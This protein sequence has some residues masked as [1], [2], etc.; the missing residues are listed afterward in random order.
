MLVPSF[1]PEFIPSPGWSPYTCT[2]GIQSPVLS[3]GFY[4]PHNLLSPTHTHDSSDSTPTLP[5]SESDHSSSS[6]TESDDI[7]VTM[8]DLDSPS[9]E[10]NS[11]AQMSPVPHP[12]ELH[13]F[14]PV[15]IPHNPPL[16]VIPAVPQQHVGYFHPTSASRSGRSRSHSHGKAKSKGISYK[17]MFSILSRSSYRFN[18]LNTL[19][20]PCRFFKSGGTCPMGDECTL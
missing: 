10:W 1:P 3:P 11:N 6:T 12:T 4:I 16:T 20:K 14:S 13:A 15:C 17:C 2:T 9:A 19:A 8:N 18:A 7:V 5:S